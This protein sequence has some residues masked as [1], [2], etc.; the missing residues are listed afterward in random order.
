M[1]LSIKLRDG[2][3]NDSVVVRADG[4]EIYRKS[5][6]ST[7]LSISFADAIELT[8]DAISMT[9]Q[10]ELASGESASKSIKLQETPFVEVW[11]IDR[12]LEIR[13]SKAEVPMM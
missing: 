10:V 6:V 11:N 1:Q 7:D 5:A 2:F 13:T 3:N 12:H 4:K 8:T 9:I